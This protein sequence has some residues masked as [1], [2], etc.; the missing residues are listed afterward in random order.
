ML[1]PKKPDKFPAFSHSQALWNPG[2]HTVCSERRLCREVWQL[3][4]MQT[5]QSH[6]GMWGPRTCCRS[7]VWSC[8]ENRFKPIARK[9]KT[10]VIGFFVCDMTWCWTRASIYRRSVSWS[11]CMA[12]SMCQ[13]GVMV[14]NC[15][16]CMVMF[17]CTFYNEFSIKKK[18][19]SCSNT[20]A[21]L[22]PLKAKGILPSTSSLLNFL[23]N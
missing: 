18:K 14:N 19:K 23:W 3:S 17:T 16:N 4:I 12:V 7:Q 2:L 13:G 22:F 9:I 1:I 6:P 5:H 21:N 15:C 20:K 10:N 11:I 8:S